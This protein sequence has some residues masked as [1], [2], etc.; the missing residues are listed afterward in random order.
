MRSFQSSAKVQMNSQKL[1]ESDVRKSMLKNRRT[2]LKQTLEQLALD[3]KII[4]P[5]QKSLSL[6]ASVVSANSQTRHVFTFKR[7]RPLVGIMTVVSQEQKE[8]VR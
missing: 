4:R 6:T 8:E 3:Q 5:D 1:P 7:Q 2:D